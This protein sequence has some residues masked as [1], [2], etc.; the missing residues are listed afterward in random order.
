MNPKLTIILTTL[1]PAQT[2]D[3]CLQLPWTVY[4]AQDDPVQTARLAFAKGT[5]AI[6]SCPPD[7][8]PVKTM[9]AVP[10][11]LHEWP[12]IEVIVVSAQ[13]GEVVLQAVRDDVTRTLNPRPGANDISQALLDILS[14]AGALPAEDVMIG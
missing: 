10:Q 12:D 13:S 4:Y 3:L 14:R 5:G 9:E 1:S 7:W 2:A 6:V 8:H 11:M